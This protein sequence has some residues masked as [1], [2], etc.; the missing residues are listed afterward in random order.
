MKTSP[1]CEG[2][3]KFLYGILFLSALSLESELFIQNCFTQSD[4]FRCYF[5]KLIVC[6]EFHTLFKRKS[7]WRNKLQCL[8][9]SA[10]TGVGNMLFLANITDDI[11]VLAHSPTIIPLIN[12]NAGT[13]EKSASVLCIPKSVACGCACFVNND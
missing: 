5:Q 12:I 8:V 10:C 11:F 6:K 7:S 4:G 13:D 2:G 1:S 9:R 3:K